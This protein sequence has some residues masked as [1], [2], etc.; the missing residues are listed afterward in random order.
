MNQLSTFNPAAFYRMIEDLIV[1]LRAK[2][3]ENER[4]EVEIF[5]EEIIGQVDLQL[6]QARRS[7]SGTVSSWSELPAGTA[8]R[9]MTET[10]S[11]IATCWTAYKRRQT[12]T[13]VALAQRALAIWNEQVRRTGEL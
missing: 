9:L 10:R 6:R 3:N 13:A 1:H 2:R 11:L 7:D 8:A 5:C 12:E 4:F